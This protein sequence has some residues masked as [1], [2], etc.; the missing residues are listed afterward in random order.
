MMFSAQLFKSI[1]MTKLSFK[2]LDSGFHFI[3]NIYKMDFER[4]LND[5]PE[6]LSINQNNLKIN[7]LQ[8]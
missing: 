4:V 2:Y 8:E 6:Q 3:I 1:I 7:F 5:T